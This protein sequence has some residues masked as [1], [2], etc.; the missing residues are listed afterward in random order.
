MWR[1]WKSCSTGVGLMLTVFLLP[2][3]GPLLR[4]RPRL[5]DGVLHRR[6]WRTAVQAAQ[7]HG[8]GLL[9]R[10]LC[11]V[12]ILHHSGA[13][14][15]REGLLTWLTCCVFGEAEVLEVDW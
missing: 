7:Q 4:S 3:S 14:V 5:P 11:S 12:H 1:T 13:A 9:L 10:A 6:G 2:H 15:C 8:G